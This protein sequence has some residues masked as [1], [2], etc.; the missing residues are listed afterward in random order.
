[1]AKIKNKWLFRA[2]CGA[3]AVTLTAVMTPVLDFA[4]IPTSITVNAAELRVKD[5]TQGSYYDAGTVI[6]CGA[7]RITIYLD[8][9]RIQYQ[10]TKDYTVPVRVYVS[11]TSNVLTGVGYVYTVRF[12]TAKLN[13]NPTISATSKT[14]NGS[15]VSWSATG[16]YGTRTVKFAGING[17]NYS[18]SSTAPSTAGS[19]RMTVTYAGNENYNSWT[20]TKDFTISRATPSYTVPSNLTVLRGKTLADITLPTGWTWVT[21]STSVGD[22][23]KHTFKANYTPADNTNY[24]SVNNVDVPVTVY[25]P[26]HTVIWNNYDGTNLET[27]ENVEED[28]TPEYNGATPEQD[29]TA[30]YTYTF[31]G[32][33]SDGG[34]NVYTAQTLPA[35]TGDVTYTAVF[36]STLNSYTVTW[37]DGDGI[38][39][40]DTVDYGT[41]PTAPENPTKSSDGIYTYTFSDWDKEITAVTGDVTYTAQ[42]DE[43]VIIHDDDVFVNSTTTTPEVFV[44]DCRT[45]DLLTEGT[46]YTVT[47]NNDSTVTVEGAGSYT[48]RV[49][50]DYIVLD[51]KA[52][53]SVA[54]RRRAVHNAKAN[55]SGEWYLPKNATN[56]K[57][58]IAR[59]STD[60]TNVI[61][62]NIYRYGV[63]KFSTLKTTSGKYSFSLLM[64]STHAIQNLYTITCVTYEV[65]GKKL[66]SLSTVF[67]SYPNPV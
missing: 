2:L 11:S 38:A 48:G 19:Y 39:T 35:V 25:I 6:K 51:R 31:S 24:N 42:F 3:L 14:Y 53:S 47:I 37:V 13:Q 44:T 10:S 29:S 34:N 16:G 33:T 64:N 28:T 62:Y 43:F 4:G 27:D 60:D 50:K 41:I 18:S 12:T 67:T 66:A 21:P 49:Q 30:Q 46:D 57:A 52:V 32:W 63:K 20:G 55:L 65:D 5:V 7:Y 58:G 40:T 22:A 9:S 15:A 56:I 59:I 61:N 26:V 1:M 17:T 8:G 54:N 23:G 45:A 36:D